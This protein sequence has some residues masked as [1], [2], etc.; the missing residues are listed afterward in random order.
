M[1]IS[2]IL[3]ALFFIK[4]FILL[5]TKTLVMLS[6][7]LFNRVVKNQDEFNEFIK[8]ANLKSKNFIIK[9]NWYDTNYA[10]FTEAKA[11]EKLIKS[12]D[13]KIT[14]VEGYSPRCRREAN[15]ESGFQLFYY[16][17]TNQQ[18]GTGRSGET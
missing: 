5:I 15:K 1:I 7:Q 6:D 18:T 8:E 14:V 13:G 10:E 4:R 9:P 17:H 2:A 3:T 11:L 12:L 16:T